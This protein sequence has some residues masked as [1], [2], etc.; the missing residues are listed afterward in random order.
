[1]MQVVGETIEA[2]PYK[3]CSA[4]GQTPI[5][6]DVTLEKDELYNLIDFI[7][8]EFIESIRRD[9]EIDNIDYV[10]NMMSALNKLRLAYACIK[11]EEESAEIN[12]E[13]SK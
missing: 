3:Q 10:V 11:L 2:H 8:I 5:S 12:R 6:A 1:M 13:E 9:E 7:E 4:T